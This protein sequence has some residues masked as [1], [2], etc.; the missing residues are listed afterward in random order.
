MGEQ[1]QP[2]TLRIG[3][4]I[5]GGARRAFT[6]SGGVL[7]VLLFGYTM[8]FVGAVNRLFIGVLPAEVRESGEIGFA[9]P[10]PPA[11]AA[12]IVGLGLLFG[13]VLYL[14][15]TRVLTRDPEAL[16]SL[17]PGLFTR[18]IGRA[19]VSTIGASVVTQLAIAVGFVLLVVPGIFLAVSFMFV[20]FAIGVEDRRAIDSLERSWHLASGNRWGLFALLLVVVVI[21]GIGGAIGSV[22]SFVAPSAGTV[23][24]LALTSVLSIVSY[25]I[26]AEAYLQLRDDADVGGGTGTVDTGPTTA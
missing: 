17:P 18:R 8:V 1:R 19:T 7:M 4:A 16:S 26:F 15:A 10:V 13:I 3:D 9:L 21:A 22:I 11:V 14:A 20:V 25:G 2:M 23:A 5:G 12:G 24:S 6:R